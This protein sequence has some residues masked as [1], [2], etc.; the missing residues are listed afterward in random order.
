MAAGLSL[1]EFQTLR[2]APYQNFVV[3]HRVKTMW[4]EVLNQIVFVFS[5][6]YETKWPSL[7]QT[8]AQYVHIKKIN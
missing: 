2:P 3:L 8:T 4:H 1:L 5:V 6:E 7:P